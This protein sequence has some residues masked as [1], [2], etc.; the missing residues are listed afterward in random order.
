MN[1]SA[2]MKNIDD[3]IFSLRKIFDEEI[4]NKKCF[5]RD[6]NFTIG[7]DL[8]KNKLRLYVED[9]NVTRNFSNGEIKDHITV[10]LF[11][12]L[13]FF[14]KISLW[15]ISENTENEKDFFVEGCFLFPVFRIRK[16]EKNKIQLKVIPDYAN[17]HNYTFYGI[18]YL[19]LNKKKF[20]ENTTIIVHGILDSNFD[21]T[22]SLLNNRY[23][24][25]KIGS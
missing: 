5:F 19:D 10:N 2:D 4:F 11:D 3:A 23:L 24:D 16:C 17:M 20:L 21:N 7:I 1:Y 15:T 6:K 22:C 25:L 14:M 8:N 12:L 13:I 18:E 9:I